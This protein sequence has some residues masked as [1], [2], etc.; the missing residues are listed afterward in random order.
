MFASIWNLRKAETA[1]I[2]F[3]KV[4]EKKQKSFCTPPQTKKCAFSN[5]E[6]DDVAQKA[7]LGEALSTCCCKQK[8]VSA[9]SKIAFERVL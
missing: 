2:I 5:K 6:N 9:K 7:F 4:T 8:R 1:Q 3:A